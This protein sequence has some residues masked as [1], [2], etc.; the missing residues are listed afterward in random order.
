[1][2]DKSF[3]QNALG[4]IFTVMMGITFLWNLFALISEFNYKV[5]IATAILFLLIFLS[6]IINIKYNVPVWI[7]VVF[8]FALSMTVRIIWVLNIPTIPVSDFE[9]LYNAS[10]DWVNGDFSFV[11]TPYFE[12]WSYQLGF[13]WFQSIIIRVLGEGIIKLK[14]VNC[15]ISS[16]IVIVGYFAAKRLFESEYALITG[17]L[18]AFDISMISMCSVLTN[19]H[20]AILLF[21]ITLYLLVTFNKNSYVWAVAGILLSIGNLMRPLGI[22]ILTSVILYNLFIINFK[23]FKAKKRTLVLCLFLACYFACTFVT[24]QA[25]IMSG[26]TDQPLGNKDPLWK[27]VTGLNFET[28]GKYSEDDLTLLNKT[29]SADERHELEKDII[30]K[31]ITDFEKLPKLF[32][33]KFRIMWVNKD[34]TINWSVNNITSDNDKFFGYFDKSQVFSIALGLDKA[35]Y[36]IGLAFSFIGLLYIVFGNE[37]LGN[38]VYLFMLIVVIY[39]GVHLLIE[40]Q[41]R[42]RM[43]VLTSIYMFSPMGAK[44]LNINLFYARRRKSKY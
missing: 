42:Y 18:I 27:F 9:L 33:Q 1:M 38:G 16:L 44:A 14:I 13:T 17:L 8:L 25:F 41:P 29:K 7:Q 35:I 39:I 2:R 19:Q 4:I 3:F 30:K 36:T 26:V 34:Y 22:V 5:S 12:N 10:S 11:Q 31:R 15:F 24:N 28:Q 23:I 20:I 6:L 37:S 32:I 40:I 21:Y 43:F